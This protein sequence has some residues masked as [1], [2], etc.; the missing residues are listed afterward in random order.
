MVKKTIFSHLKKIT[1][2]KQLGYM[3]LVLE[4]C[5]KICLDYTYKKYK[6]L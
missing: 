4:I 6:K 5:N 3:K 1:D 2:S